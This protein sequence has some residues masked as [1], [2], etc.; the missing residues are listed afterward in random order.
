M[1]RQK[2]SEESHPDFKNLFESEFK[3]DESGMSQDV[4]ALYD[5]LTILVKHFETPSAV[6]FF[7]STEAKQKPS[8]A[9]DMVESGV[10]FANQIPEENLARV[11]FAAI[12]LGGSTL[13]KFINVVK[14]ID[15]N[16]T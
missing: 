9:R 16:K 10:R 1:K 3:E 8:R 11:I 5:H 15:H 13:T 4:C 12:L 6:T 7:K 2:T 14:E